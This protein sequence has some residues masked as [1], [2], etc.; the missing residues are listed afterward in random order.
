MFAQIIRF[1]NELHT[2]TCRVQCLS[3]NAQLPQKQ[4]DQAAGYDLSSI[5]N[6]TIPPHGRALVHTGLRVAP[7]PH[8]HIEIRPRSGLALKHGITVLNAPGTVDSDYR[9]ELMVLLF[10]TSETPF[11]I[12]TGD[13][14]A[15]AVFMRH[16]DVRWTPA[17][18]FDKTTRGDKGFGSTGS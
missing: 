10:N 4:S 15:Q 14:I 1:L 18:S 8:T 2:L 6:L 7:P 11:E 5:E 12:H 13:R 9:G 16:L 17:A 3:H